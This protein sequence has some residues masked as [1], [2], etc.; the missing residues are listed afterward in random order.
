MQALYNDD[1]PY[2]IFRNQ[3]KDRID[4]NIRRVY[5][6]YGFEDEI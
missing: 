3:N 5:L 4:Q 2:I 1:M 6:A